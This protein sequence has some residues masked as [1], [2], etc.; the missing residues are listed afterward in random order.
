LV[1]NRELIVINVEALLLLLDEKIATL[2]QTLTKAVL[3]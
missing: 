2:D 1:A 3:N